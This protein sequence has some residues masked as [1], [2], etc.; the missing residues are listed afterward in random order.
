MKKIIIAAGLLIATSTYAQT[1]VSVGV[2]RGKDYGVVYAL[3]QTQIQLEL[4]TNK[5]SYTPGEFSKYADRYLR[6]TNVAADAYEYWELVGVTIK[7][8]G[9]PNNAATY[10]VKLKDRTAAPLIELTEDGI[11]KSINIPYSGKKAEAAKPTLTPPKKVNPREFLTEEI[12][13]TNSTAK[14]AELVAKEIYNIRESKN[15]LLRGQADNTPSD[16]AQLKIMLD[17]LN[18]QEEAMT[19][20]FSGTSE[21]EEKTFIV[22]ITPDKELNNEVAFRFSKKLG[23]V[24]NNDLAGAPYYINVKDLKSVTIPPEDPKKKKE[25]DGIAYNVPGK[26]LVTLT[27]GKQKLYEEEISVTQFGVLEFLAPVLF[28]KNSTIKVLFDP[29]TGALIKV[30]REEG[31]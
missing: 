11:V 4:K 6:L 19:E 18:L 24:A 15:A 21:K 10:F 17:N 26:A 20:M 31:K 16:G 2:T 29:T 1:E 22:R 14:M 7:A 23:V 3:P 8:V 28:N 30:D 9:V 13:M 5:V 25:L 27:D 12:L